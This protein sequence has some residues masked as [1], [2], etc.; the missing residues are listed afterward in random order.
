[1]LPGTLPTSTWHGLGAAVRPDAL[2]PASPLHLQLPVRIALSGEGYA[3]QSGRRMDGLRTHHHSERQSA[4]PGST[5][6]VEPFTERQAPAGGERS[7]PGG[8]CARIHLRSDRD[9]R[10]CEGPAGELGEASLLQ[11]R[12]VQIVVRFP[13]MGQTTVPWFREHRRRHRTR[14]APV[15]LR[16]PGRQDHEDR[17]KTNRPVP[18]RILQHL[19]SRAVRNSGLHQPGPLRQQWA[20]VHQRSEPGRDQPDGGCSRLIQFAL[21]YSF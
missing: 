18:R 21:K 15:E 7:E 5:T 6:A 8:T 19:Q 3:G 12:R 14:A 20:A 13:V 16:L 2:Q 9:F 1:M 11:Y 4:D 17:R 10:Q